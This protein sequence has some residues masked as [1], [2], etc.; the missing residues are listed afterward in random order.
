[1]ILFDSDSC[2]RRQQRSSR[3]VGIKTRTFHLRT[4]QQQFSTTGCSLAKSRQRKCSSKRYWNSWHI[5]RVQCRIEPQLLSC[6]RRKAGSAGY[7]IL[8][9]LY[10]SCDE[11]QRKMHR[12]TC[13]W[14]H[15]PCFFHA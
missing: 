12:Y 13:F 7:V 10:C 2:Q 4:Y 9:C 5:R 8:F 11:F 6:G 3:V 1:M 14:S 15:F